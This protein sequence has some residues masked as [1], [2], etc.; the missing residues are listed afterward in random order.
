MRG[1]GPTLIRIAHPAV[2]L[3][4]GTEEGG[5]QLGQTLHQGCSR[6]SRSMS[7]IESGSS[8]FPGRKLLLFPLAILSL[9]LSLAIHRVA[10][11]SHRVVVAVA[12]HPVAIAAVVAVASRPVVVAAARTVK[13]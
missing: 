8:R 11:A 2:R 12:G 10:V 3:D 13:G 7:G 4:A 9:P 6:S 5:S 1:L